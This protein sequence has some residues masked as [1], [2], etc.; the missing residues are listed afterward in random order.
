MPVSVKTNSADDKTASEKSALQQDL[1]GRI[2][3]LADVGFDIQSHA[4]KLILKQVPASLR[5]LPWVSILP[6]LINAECVLRNEQDL[7]RFICFCWAQSYT[8]TYSELQHWFSDIQASEQQ[9]LI[10][11][12][13]SAIAVPNVSFSVSE[14]RDE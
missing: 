11:A 6:M 3:L 12:H 8:F 2:K 4:N 13:A 10:D 7:L 1:Q 5:Q 14:Q 9:R